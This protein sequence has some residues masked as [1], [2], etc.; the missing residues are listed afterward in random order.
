M[1]VEI[2]HFSMVGVYGAPL[3]CGQLLWCNIAISNKWSKVNCL[4]CHQAKKDPNRPDKQV[5]KEYML[6]KLVKPKEK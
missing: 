5:Y 4:Q 6:R 1:T 2:I 3:A